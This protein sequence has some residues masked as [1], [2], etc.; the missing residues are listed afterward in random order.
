MYKIK[1]KTNTYECD[2]HKFLLYIIFPF[3]T[4]VIIRSYLLIFINEEKLIRY[5]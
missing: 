2:K 3:Y 1:F 4:L 5:K